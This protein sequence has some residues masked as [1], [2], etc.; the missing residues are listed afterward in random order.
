[1]KHTHDVTEDREVD[2]VN[3]PAAA[4]KKLTDGAFRS[5]EFRDDGAPLREVRKRQD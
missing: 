3:V 4:K 5:G 1:M 2:A